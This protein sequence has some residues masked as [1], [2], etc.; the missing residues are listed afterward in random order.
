MITAI[1][2]GLAHSIYFVYITSALS[3]YNYSAP[4]FM[5]GGWWGYLHS[6]R[7][8]SNLKFSPESYTSQNL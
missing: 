6:I 5:S 1:A 2:A 3:T 7:C 8:E 4:N